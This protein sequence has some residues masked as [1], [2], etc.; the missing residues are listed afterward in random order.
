MISDKK[1][2]RGTHIRKFLVNLFYLKKKTIQNHF[3]C[4]ANF[5][6]VIDI[7]HRVYSFYIF[8]YNYTHLK[9]EV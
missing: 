6:Y 4:Q 7:K 9:S 8:C 1:L 5:G 2:R 3:V